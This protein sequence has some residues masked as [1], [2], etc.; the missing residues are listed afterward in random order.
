MILR[1]FTALSLA[2]G[3]CFASVA[4]AA[5]KPAPKAPVTM[6]HRAPKR[7]TI[8]IGHHP[9]FHGQGRTFAKTH[10]RRVNSK[11]KLPARG[12]PMHKMMLR[13]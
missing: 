10:I 5:P 3:L 1:T 8:K 4:G 9:R 2:V 7:G 11:A 6:Q 12:R 13:K